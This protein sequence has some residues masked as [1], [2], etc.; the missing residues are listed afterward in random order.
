MKN[1]YNRRQFLKTAGSLPAV[2]AVAL[3]SGGYW[4][5]AAEAA[6]VDSAPRLAVSSAAP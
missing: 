1:D 5:R 6:G 4:L 3:A 2:S